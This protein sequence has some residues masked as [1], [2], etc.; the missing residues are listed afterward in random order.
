MKFRSIRGPNCVDASVRVTIV[1]E[2]TTPTTVITAAASAA[3]ICLAESAVPL[4][5]HVGS[6]RSPL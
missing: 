5:I 4:I 1:I 2:K 3:R 6:D